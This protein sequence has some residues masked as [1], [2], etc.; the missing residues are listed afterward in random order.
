[1]VSDLTE[2]QSI[3]PA[4]AAA[5]IAAGVP[6]AATLRA[7]GAHEAYRAL[8]VAGGRPHF[9]WYYV[10]H[11]SLQGRPWNDCRGEEKAALR[12]RFDAL[13][14]EVRGRPLSGIE[15]ALDEIGLPAPRG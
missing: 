11:M 6:D 7:I 4:T 3:G 2:M 13:V 10:L 1:M 12:L 5:L 14:A 15:A 9:I 8:L